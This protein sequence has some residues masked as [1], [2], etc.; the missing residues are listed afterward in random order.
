[1]NMP[2][3]MLIPTGHR[4]A[5]KLLKFLSDYL[6]RLTFTYFTNNF[7][8]LFKCLQQTVSKSLATNKALMM[9]S[10]FQ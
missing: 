4:F 6:K 2:I 1:M 3:A 5:K 9:Y 10:V 8:L 7:P